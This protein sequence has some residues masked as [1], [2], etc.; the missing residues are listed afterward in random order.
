MSGGLRLANP[1]AVLSLLDGLVCS[2]PGF[3]VVWCRFG[4]LR[5][6]MA[7]NS[8][9]HELARVKVFFELSPLVLLGMVLST[10]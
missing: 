3:H 4:M 5:R 1:G 2:D 10:C 7:Y 8:S 9:V 6:H